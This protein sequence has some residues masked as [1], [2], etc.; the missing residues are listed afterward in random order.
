VIEV[1]TLPVVLI[2]AAGYALKRC[3]WFTLNISSVICKLRLASWDAGGV[4]RSSQPSGVCNGLADH[5]SVQRSGKQP[6]I[7]TG[8]VMVVAQYFE[9]CEHRF[10]PGV[11]AET[12]IDADDLDQML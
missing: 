6:A 12:T 8:E 9:Y 5:A 11:V 2:Y 10:S 3:R 7:L 4:G 1:H